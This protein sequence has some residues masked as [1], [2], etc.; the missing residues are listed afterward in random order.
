MTNEHFHDGE[1]LLQNEVGVRAQMEVAAK[2]LMRDFMIDEHRK[3]FEGLEYIFLGTATKDDTPRASLLTGPKGFVSSADPTILSIH[4]GHANQMSELTDLGVGDAVG[5]LGLD[6]SNRRRNRM[7]GR[8]SAI[9]AGKIDIKVTQSYGNCPK[10][11]NTRE[12]SERL[13]PVVDQSIHHSE[14]LNSSDAALIKAADTV[15]ISSYIRDGSGAAYEGADISHRGGQAGFVTLEGTNTL[16]IPDYKGNNLFN[17]FGNLL[18]NPTAALLFIGFETGDQLHLTGQTSLVK[19]ASEVSAYPGALRLL[20]IDI[21][22]VERKNATISL[23]W[24]YNETSQLNP[25]VKA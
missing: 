23:R 9:S 8:V 2:H 24:N 6:L 12:I 10:Y 21:E 4:P 20:R 17:T 18:L 25:K 7:H 22:T 11:I 13:D 15:F 16:I 19:E 14:T 1:I 3:F 5:V